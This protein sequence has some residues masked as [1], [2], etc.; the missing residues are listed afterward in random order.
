MLQENVIFLRIII[1]ME[2]M[3]QN[4]I[5]DNDLVLM[6]LAKNEDFRYII[7]RYEQKL[8][9][10]IQRTLFV[11]KE[12]TEDILQEVFIKVYKNLNSFKTKFKFS[13]WIYGITYH[14]CVNH[15]R[16][17]KQEKLSID[18]KI[19][20]EIFNELKSDIDLESEVMVE[21]TSQ[22]VQGILSKL[23]EKYKTV[24]VL[25]YIEEKDYNEIADIL[26]TSTGNVGSLINRAK[27]KFKELIKH[28]EIK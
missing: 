2:R 21:E 25:K 17:F 19:E 6:A 3:D 24:L 26:K 7:E 18:L 5:N 12:D 23:E 8:F 15:L 28:V 22:S 11:N 9:R 4:L 1:D 10:Y 14:E 27:N 16:K 13:S 20:Q